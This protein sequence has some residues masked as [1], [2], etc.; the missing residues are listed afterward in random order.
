MKIKSLADE[1][2]ITKVILLSPDCKLTDEELMR[3][4]QTIANPTNKKL[5]TEDDFELS[6]NSA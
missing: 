4:N 1:Q 3:E 2:V 6:D 5:K